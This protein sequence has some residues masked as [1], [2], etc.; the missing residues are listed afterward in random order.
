MKSDQIFSIFHCPRCKN[1]IN[2]ESK[3]CSKC[4]IHI[5]DLIGNCAKCG[6]V[7]LLGK[8]FCSQ[9]KAP[10]M[11]E[12]MGMTFSDVGIVYFNLRDSEYLNRAQAYFNNSNYADS[13]KALL[14]E[15]NLAQIVKLYKDE[16][17]W[18]HEC[19]SQVAVDNKS[20]LNRVIDL[21]DR[22]Y[23]KDEAKKIQTEIFEN[24]LRQ[25][26]DKGNIRSQNKYC[27]YLYSLTKKDEYKD[28]LKDLHYERKEKSR[29]HLLIA[30]FKLVIF[31]FVSAC[32]FDLLF[33]ILFGYKFPLK[34]SGL[35][36]S[37]VTGLRA[38]RFIP[39]FFFIGLSISTSYW[40]AFSGNFS[41]RNKK[42]FKASLIMM[43]VAFLVAGACWG[44][45]ANDREGVAV[46]IFVF[47]ILL[48]IA[49]QIRGIEGIFDKAWKK[50]LWPFLTLFL[51]VFSTIP[52]KMAIPLYRQPS[53]VDFV[54][55]SFFSFSFILLQSLFVI[56][57]NRDTKSRN[58]RVK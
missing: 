44:E 18:I 26:Q 50:I 11:E 17:N 4:G 16:L 58:L 30:A 52:G 48:F 2:I 29:K 12:S 39:L 42:K 54:G 13:F 40:F 37:T 20:Y 46:V 45:I 22:I 49:F 35:S 14:K 31:G 51:L 34:Y 23:S 25:A 56:L 3:I 32:L 38:W 53:Q 27:R 9:C 28:K 8:R 36:L 1:V 47:A 6:S 19:L 15:D 57:I 33:I 5:E 41:Y 21:S 7:Y 10:L 24:L 55:I 43:T